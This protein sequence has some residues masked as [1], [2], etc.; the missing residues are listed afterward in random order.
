MTDQIAALAA[1]VHSGCPEAEL[2]LAR[3]A[4]QWSHDR[5]VM[6]KWF[7]VQ[8]SAPLDQTPQRVAELLDHPAFD[9]RNPNRARALLGAFGETNPYC[10]HAPDGRGYRILSDQVIKLNDLNPN[11]AAR[12][13]SPLTR[14]Q[15][16]DTE[17]QVLMKTE[18]LRIAEL[19]KLSRNLYELVRRSLDVQDD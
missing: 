17:R 5:L 15:R 19:D 10:F 3:F 13:L 7:A 12:L 16:Y 2:A 6:D 8:A 11:I 4:E 1:L 9:L 14:W 18:L